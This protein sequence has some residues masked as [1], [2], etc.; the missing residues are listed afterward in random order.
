MHP[1]QWVFRNQLHQGRGNIQSSI[2]FLGFGVNLPAYLQDRRM[3]VVLRRDL[4]QL[5]VC[6]QMIPKFNLPLRGLKVEAVRRL[7]GFHSSLQPQ[8]R[9]G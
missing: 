2:P 4:L 7:Q 5:R 1:P 8:K 3:R 9:R 6:L